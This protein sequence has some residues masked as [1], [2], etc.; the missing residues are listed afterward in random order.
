MRRLTK[1]IGLVVVLF[2]LGMMVNCGIGKS[3]YVGTYI[4]EEKLTLGKMVSKLELKPDGTYRYE[5]KGP[6]VGPYVSTGEWRIL[7]DDGEDFVE[8]TPLVTLSLRKSKS[9]GYYFYNP[10]SS[11]IFVKQK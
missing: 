8:F 4:H 1:A 3:K 10:V 6:Y 7:K 5:T 9:K 2:V 11:D